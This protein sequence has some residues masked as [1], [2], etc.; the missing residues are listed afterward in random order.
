MFTWQR[1]GS[2]HDS[3]LRFATLEGI[4]VQAHAIATSRNLSWAKLA[5]LRG[6]V[7]AMNEHGRL[8]GGR[9]SRHDIGATNYVGHA[10]GDGTASQNATAHWACQVPKLHYCLH[11]D[12][13]S[14]LKRFVFRCERVHGR[15]EKSIDRVAMQIIPFNLL[16]IRIYRTCSASICKSMYMGRK[17]GEIGCTF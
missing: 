12:T 15:E 10:Q 8:E 13:V 2:P 4:R 6:V 17:S 5:F 14:T 7:V 1:A 16:H 9:S 3:R 11:G